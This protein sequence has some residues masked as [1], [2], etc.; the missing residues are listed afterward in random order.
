MYSARWF[1][2]LGAT[3]ALAARTLYRIGI[4]QKRGTGSN[5][6][7]EGFV[8]TGDANLGAAFASSGTQTVTA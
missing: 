7:L 8:A 2:Q 1:D 3:A 5:G 4:R 6:A